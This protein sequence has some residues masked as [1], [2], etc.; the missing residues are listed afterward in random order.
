MD[1]TVNNVLTG[2]NA[3]HTMS[4]MNQTQSPW[5]NHKALGGV[6]NALGDVKT[7]STSKKMSVSLQ[8]RLTTV[9]SLASLR[10][11]LR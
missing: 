11:A 8:E 9:S 10:R 7:S 4:K 3:K 6:Y 1:S 5:W 2:H